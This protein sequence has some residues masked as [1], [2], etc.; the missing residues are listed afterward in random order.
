MILDE[1]T[2]HLDS[3][4]IKTIE[5][6]LST[7]LAEQQGS[8]LLVDHSTEFVSRLCRHWVYI[9]NN[10]ERVPYVLNDISYE[11]ALDE[12]NKIT[13]NNQLLLRA[14]ANKHRD[15]L[16][17]RALQTRRAEVFGV[18]LGATMK[19]IDRRIAREV[20]Q[21]DIHSKITKD[22]T[23]NLNSNQSSKSKVKKDRLIGINDLEYMIGRNKTQTVTDFKL[24]NGQRLRLIGPNGSGK[25]TLVSLISDSLLTS[26]TNTHPQH[27]SGS[28]ESSSQLNTQNVF[29]LSQLSMYAQDFMLYPYVAQ[30]LQYQDY[31]IPSF[32]KRLSLHHY[33][34]NA[35]LSSLS[36]GELTRL[37]FGILS[38][39]L[40]KQMLIILDE[41][42]NFLD[43][44]TQNTLT[45]LL[46]TYS[47]G[48]I[49]ISHSDELATKIG[50]DSEYE[51]S[52]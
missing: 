46:S 49:L 1:I 38:V 4:S 7:Y 29:I 45:K 25:S 3:G 19:N 51:L 44:F 16:K 23:I 14:V 39:T 36:L 8:I 27:C 42:G 13:S 37:Q 2:N 20:E 50:Y 28:I 43:V 21:N 9:P 5:D 11:E 33:A 17:A 6:Y 52:I 47:G 41:P 15:L 31:Q 24:Y 12:I 22:R 10:D 34:S 40:P 48:V 26:S 35:L 30:K 32:L 18:D